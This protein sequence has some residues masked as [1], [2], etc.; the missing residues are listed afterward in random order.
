MKN[1]FENVFVF[2]KR[3][4]NSYIYLSS[5]SKRANYYVLSVKKKILARIYK[6]KDDWY[7]WYEKVGCRRRVE[8]FTQALALLEAEVSNCVA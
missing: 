7:I 4:L 2:N 5:D 6:I 8:S 3:K 1:N